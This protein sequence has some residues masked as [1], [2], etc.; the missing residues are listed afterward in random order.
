MVEFYTDIR[1]VKWLYTTFCLCFLR[2]F[3][4]KIHFFRVV[5][6]VHLLLEKVNLAPLNLVEIVG[7]C[8]YCR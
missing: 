2:N 7:E 8:S 5:T 6:S 3:R 4:N 1:G